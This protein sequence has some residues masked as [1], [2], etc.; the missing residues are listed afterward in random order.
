MR[1]IETDQGP[2]FIQDG[3]LWD[4]GLMAFCR[5]VW[6]PRDSSWM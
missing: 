6:S 3:S 1:N 5:F 4:N 2:G